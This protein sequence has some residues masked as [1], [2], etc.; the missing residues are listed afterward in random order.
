[1]DTYIVA[2]LLI[3][4]DIMHDKKERY[5][6]TL[7]LVESNKALYT[8]TMESKDTLDEYYELF[9]AQVN[10]I[11]AYGG[12]LRY[13]DALYQEHYD[14]YVKSKEFAIKEKLL[15]VTDTELKKTR[16]KRSSPV[17][18]PISDAYF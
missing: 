8:I 4:H 18:G 2:L 1:M 12:N 6:S 14:A 3:I 11:K 16:L 17:P 15:E 13:Y 7:G 5:Q 9:K 10:T